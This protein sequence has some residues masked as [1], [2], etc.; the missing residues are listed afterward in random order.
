MLRGAGKKKGPRRNKDGKSSCSGWSSA[1]M[2]S[3]LDVFDVKRENE[4]DEGP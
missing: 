4:D 2:L 1:S 3:D